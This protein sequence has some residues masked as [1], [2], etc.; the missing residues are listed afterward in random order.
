MFFL[1]GASQERKSIVKL[2]CLL[3]LVFPD[4]ADTTAV[5]AAGIHAAVSGM[6]SRRFAQMSIWYESSVTGQR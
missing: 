3:V 6:I 4:Q 5:K 2:H 1:N